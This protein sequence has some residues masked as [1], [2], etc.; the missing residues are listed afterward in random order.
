LQVLPGRFAGTDDYIPGVPGLDEEVRNAAV[1]V[2][3]NGRDGSMYGFHGG[4]GCRI[5]WIAW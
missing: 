3:G 5:S 2:A 1:P 4:A